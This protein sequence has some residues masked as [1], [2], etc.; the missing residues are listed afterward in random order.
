MGTGIMLETKRQSGGEYKI[1]PGTLYD[2]LKPL[3]ANGLVTE[4]EADQAADDPR[5]LYRLTSSGAAVL[6]DELKRL[7]H[8]VKAGRRR[9]AAGSAREA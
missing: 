7:D 4:V 5:K 6:A 1:G 8:V 2:N 9:L 3:M